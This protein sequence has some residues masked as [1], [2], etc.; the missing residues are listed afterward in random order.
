[1]M[2]DGSRRREPFEGFVHN[3]ERELS[4]ERKF[5]FGFAVTH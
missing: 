2:V 1:M 4:W 5:L 3:P